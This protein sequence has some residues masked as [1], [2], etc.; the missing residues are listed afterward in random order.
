MN[1]TG[2]AVGAHTFQIRATDGA[3]NQDPTPASFAWTVTA[4]AASCGTTTT[5]TATADSWIDQGSRSSN[6]GTDSNLKVM[7]KSSN[8]LR[9]LVRFT[10]PPLPAGCVVQTA[11]LRLYAASHK[12]GRTLQA[13]PIA[14][15]WA[16][17]SVTWNNQPATTATPAT[18]SSGSGWREWNVAT[19]LQAAYTANLLHGFLIRDA[20]ETN[21]HEQQFN[22]REQ[23]SNRPQ[24]VLTFVAASTPALSTAMR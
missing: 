16:E 3:G 18:T 5:L 2:L 8:A 24:L 14:A 1:L 4:P 22:S 20:V 21:D 17:G 6:K 19:Q 10:M 7:S 12:T 23:S 15:T 9:T 11:T 13:L